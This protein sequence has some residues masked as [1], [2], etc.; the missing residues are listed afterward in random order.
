MGTFLSDAWT[1]IQDALEYFPLAVAGT[2]VWGL[3]FYRVILSRR[4]KPTVS[5]FRTTTSLVV[6]SYHE[7]PDILMRCLDTWRDQN[8]PAAVR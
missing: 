7:D 2:I 8:L 1:W 3:W 6:P 5:S 4:Y